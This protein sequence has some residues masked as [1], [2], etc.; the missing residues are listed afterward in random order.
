MGPPSKDH[1]TFVCARAQDLFGRSG[2]GTASGEE[3]PHSLSG[4]REPQALSSI[5]Q[6]STYCAFSTEQEAQADDPDSLSGSSGRMW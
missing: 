4:S 1:T 5:P 6:T 3:L 2:Q